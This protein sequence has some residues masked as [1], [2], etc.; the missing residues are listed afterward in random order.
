L[1]EPTIRFFIQLRSS[2]TVFSTNVIM[3]MMAV[4]VMMP[5]TSLREKTRRQ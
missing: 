4:M 3:V 1:Q 5:M 2:A